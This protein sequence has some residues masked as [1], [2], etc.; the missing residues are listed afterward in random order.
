MPRIK[1]LGVCLLVLLATQSVFGMLPQRTASAQNLDP[2]IPGPL[3]VAAAEYTFGNTSFK[4]PGFPTPVELT[5][6]VYHPSGLPGGPFPFVL[7]LHGR[8]ET[9]S[10]GLSTF[11]EWP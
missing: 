8:H 9:C 10:L 11:L 3:P 6:R 7:F 2:G 4:P 1:M 5:G